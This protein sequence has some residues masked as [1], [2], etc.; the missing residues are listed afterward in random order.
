MK[1]LGLDPEPAARQP[2]DQ[3]IVLLNPGELSGNTK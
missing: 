3:Q 2:N 1:R